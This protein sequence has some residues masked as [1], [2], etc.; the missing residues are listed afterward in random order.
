MIKFVKQNIDKS[1][2]RFL[3]VGSTCTCMDYLL[4]SIISGK[5]G[6]VIGK[7]ISM[8]CSITIGFILNKFWSFSV[9]SKIDRKEVCRYCI[10]QFL[11]LSINVAIN[12]VSYSITAN[13]NLSFIVATMCATCVNYSLQRYWVFKLE[14]SKS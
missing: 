4:Y 3:F 5:C 2:I 10:T 8:L 11:N 1:S 9:K 14:N 12:Q 6:V 7:T 13:K